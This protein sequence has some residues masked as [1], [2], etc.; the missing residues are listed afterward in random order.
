M[1]TP[2]RRAGQGQATLAFAR[3]LGY[4]QPGTSSPTRYLLL[5]KGPSLSDYSAVRRVLIITMVLNYA[6]S[7]I[8]LAAG[9]LTGSLSILADSLDILFDGTSNIV[10]L[11]GIYLANRPPDR[12]HPYGHRKFETMA[13]LV[14]AFLLLITGWELARSALGRFGSPVVPDVNLWSAL[15][16]VGSIVIQAVTSWYEKQRGQELKSEVLIADALHSRASI[17]ISVS[18][19]A[20]LALVRLGFGWVDSLLALFI[21]AVIVRIGLGIVWENSG[22]LVDKAPLDESEIAHLAQSVAGVQFVHRV[23]SRGTA[24]DIAVDLH[25]H[26]ARDLSVD[27]S[28]GIADEVRRKLMA[29][30]PGV[31]DVTVHVEPTAA[32]MHGERD[33]FPT[34]RQVAARYPVTVHEIWAKDVEGKLYVE[35][36]V[37]V[38]RDL[39][40]GQAHDLVSRVEQ[41]SRAR[42]PAVAAIH[43]HIEF[44]S[45][46][47]VRGK[48]APPR[49]AQQA[50]QEAA[51]LPGAIRYLQGCHAIR[52]QEYESKLFIAL[53][54]TVDPGL[55]LEDAHE[56]ASQVEDR[57][58][59]RMPD[60]GGVAVHVEPPDAQD[61]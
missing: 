26:V 43:T 34:I 9:L 6:A 53:H 41:E 5:E 48:P 1:Y 40:L 36:D 35:M 2:Y 10:G 59:E 3:G 38:D 17:L 27:R 28:N 20:G 56:V 8:T 24:N 55:S 57:L 23:R 7:A 21:A 29:E 54:C 52:V 32:P 12:E 44:A 30:L 14:I 15:A 16:V 49:L 11:V 51:L 22:V 33:I 13:A 45:D 39:T 46:E 4:N 60:V 42:L 47:I 31:R 50:Q 58:R 25:I 61:R 19:L 18:V 37:G